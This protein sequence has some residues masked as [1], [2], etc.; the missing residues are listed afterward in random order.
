[1]TVPQ[2]GR[3]ASLGARKYSS[4]AGIILFI[5]ALALYAAFSV[6]I[7]K[8]PLVWLLAVAADDAFYYLQIAR[9]LALSGRSTFDGQHVTNGYHPGWMVL[10]TL[11]A[12][13]NSDRETL[14][15]ACLGLSLILHSATASLIV[16]I[17][18]TRLE[19][20]WACIG[21]VL[22]LLNPF[23]ILVILQGVEAPL[24][25]FSV[26]LVVLVALKR[27]APLMA[28]S[29]SVPFPLKNAVQFGA[30]L[31][32]AVWARTEF[33]VG[34]V[35]TLALFSVFVVQ[36]RRPAAIKRQMFLRLAGGV[37]VTSSLLV[38]PWLLYS[39]LLVGSFSQDSGT[40]KLLWGEADYGVLSL[41]AR[42]HH[43]IAFLW[44]SWWTY[45]ITK[46]FIFTITGLPVLAL[47]IVALVQTRKQTGCV[48]W[49]WLQ[50]WL[51]TILFV[52]T[53]VYGWFFAAYQ[54]WHYCLPYFVLFLLVYGKIAAWLQ[55]HA[56][57][58]DR[59][60][61]AV[62]QWSLVSFILVGFIR[63]WQHPATPYTWQRDVYLSQPKFESMIRP[64]ARIG[65]FNAGIPGYFSDRTVINL[66]GLVNHSVVRY[67]REHR[68]ERYLTDENIEYVADEKA[69]LHSAERFASQPLFLREITKAYLTD[70]WPPPYRYLWHVE[71]SRV[72]SLGTYT[73][74]NRKTSCEFE[75][76]FSSMLSPSRI[77]S[78]PVRT[79][80]VAPPSSKVTRY[81]AVG[82][83]PCSTKVC[84]DSGVVPR[85]AK[86]TACF[87]D[88]SQYS[89]PSQR[90][91]SGR[92]L[93]WYR[94]PP[95]ISGRRRVL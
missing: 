67:W 69:T 88:G 73:Y 40:I 41:A 35:V 9:H 21:G 72:T 18:R 55:T 34:L 59:R 13:L 14:F 49:R 75:G 4:R 19:K 5:S 94:S 20:T 25:L 33:F 89:I 63:N 29:D 56:R 47:L 31:A 84:R 24:Y 90:T 60:V 8:R 58:S 79:N 70:W 22:W 45:G 48:Q 52:N 38:A 10:T 80:P 68:L 81:C 30:V 85:N 78:R 16:A 93:T 37:S 36:S 74:R 64:E 61:Q 57:M 42:L 51:L 91:P 26:A 28:P 76:V 86:R 65:C 7:L 66:D 83:R 1:V 95:T 15:R 53:I 87:P 46:I 77:R 62:L 54:L 12:K 23:G 50:T 3:M 2:N 43:V 71:K 6:A 17:L 32:L 11:L 92:S 82:S 44:E 39:H 27:I